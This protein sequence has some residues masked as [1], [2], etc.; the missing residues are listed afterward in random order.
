M[1]YQALYRKYRP[2]AFEEVVGQDIIVK[3]LKNAIKL[4]KLSHAYLFTGPRGTGKT[5]VAKLLAKIVNCSSPING[6]ACNTCTNCLS[7]NKNECSDII[8]IDAAS[9]NGVDEIREIRNKVNLVPAMLKYKV[10]IIDEVHMLSV[11]AFNALLKTL[12]EPPKHIIF[13]LATTEPHKIPSTIISRC[14]RFDFKKISD[15]DIEKALLSI[16]E[17]ENINID[18]DAIKTVARLSDGGMRDAISMLD[19]LISYCEDTIKIDD[20]YELNSLVNPEELVKLVN[21]IIENDLVNVLNIVD[22]YNK[23]GKNLIKL[24][25][26]LIYLLKNTLI[27]LKAPKYFENNNIDT[28]LYKKIIKIEEGELLQYIKEI[29]TSL[30]DMKTTTDLKTIFEL[31]M[32][33]IIK[34]EKGENH[35]ISVEKTQSIENEEKQAKVIHTVEELKELRI[36]NSLSPLNKKV[37]MDLKKRWEDIRSLTLNNEYAEMAILLLD[38]EIKAASPTNIIVVYNEVHLSE[39]FNKNLNIIE[40]ILNK[41]F[42]QEYKPI[43]VNNEEWIE[44]KN[45][46]N[47]KTTEYVYQEEIVEDYS[48]LNNVEQNI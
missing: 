44:I 34:N 13:I 33:K 12:E 1:A 29:S 25:E 35:Y 20:V 41:T 11:G 7:I 19:Q 4:E 21:S 5:S 6:E 8:E 23:R 36:N 27:Y 18:N 2:S 28:K 26:E 31:V 42:N 48:I 10:Y 24:A 45:R 46:F 37:L 17:T 15:S 43:S 32:I 30:V 9:N 16:I 38:G 14:Q 40:E 3:T 22:N 39:L 47:T